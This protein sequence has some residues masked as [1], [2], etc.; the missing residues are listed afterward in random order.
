MTLTLDHLDTDDPEEVRRHTLDVTRNWCHV[1]LWQAER[2]RQSV[3]RLTDASLERLK[4]GSTYDPTIFAE[5]DAE[6]FFLFHAVRQVNRGVW[7]LTSDSKPVRTELQSDLDATIM[8]LR[9]AWEHWDNL[10]NTTRRQLEELGDGV[11]PSKLSWNTSTNYDVGEVKIG[12]VFTLG[13]LEARTRWTSDYL[14]LLAKTP[15][16]LRDGW[17]CA[18]LPVDLPP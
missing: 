4:P 10:N 7:S 16:F 17:E 1:A 11:G 9:N 18:P 15:K 5:A 2:V 14:D 3:R 13:E 12:G 6:R 8:T